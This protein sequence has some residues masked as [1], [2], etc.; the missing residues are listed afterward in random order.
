MKVFGLEIRSQSQ[1]T[2]LRE[3]MS[4]YKRTLEDI[5]WIN[6]SMDQYSREEL[7][8]GGFHFMLKRCRIMYVN[9]PLCKHWV[10]LTTSFV[11]GRGLTVP[12]SA[13]KD[14]DINDI[15][16]NFW[17][18]PDNKKT[19]SSVGPQRM[20]SNKMQYEGNLFFM[21]FDDDEGNVRVR[22]LNTVE[23]VDIITD[24]EDR[25]KYLFYKV[26]LTNRSYDYGADAYDN[27]KTQFWYIPD[28]DNEDPKSYGVPQ[29]KLKDDCRIFHVRINCDINDKF[30]IPDLYAGLDWVKA[31]KDMAGDVAT[32][33]KALSQFA[34]KKKVKGGAAQVNNILGQMKARTNLSN[35]STM[36]GKTQIENEGIDLESIDIKTGGVD[37]GEKGLKA[38]QMMVCSASGIFYHYYGDPSTGNLATATSMELPMVKKFQD[39]QMLWTY[40]YNVIFM[41]LFRKKI[42]VGLL[43][44]SVEFD[45]KTGYMYINTPK[46]L[47]VDLDF[48]PIIEQD[49]LKLGQ[50]L[51]IA[52]AQGLVSDELASRLF[53]LGMEVDDIDIEVE[54]AMTDLQS[55]RAR[56]SQ[57]V[58]GEPANKAPIDQSSIK[59]QNNYAA[60]EIQ[61]ALKVIK[62]L[63]KALSIR[64]GAIEVPE[65]QA[66]RLARKSNY[67]NQ[68]M[69]GYRKALSGH[70]RSFQ[71]DVKESAK[72]AGS[73]DKF[74]GNVKDLSKHITKLG[75]GMKLAAKTYFPE[76][77]KIGEKYIQSHL[78]SKGHKVQE[79]LYEKQGSAAKV[80][81]KSLDANTNY[82][83]TSLLPDINDKVSGAIKDQYAS[84]D[85][86]NTA[87][88]DAV[89][90]FESRMEMYVG[91][92]WAVE[93]SAVK[94][95]GTGTGLQVNFVGPEDGD[96]CEDCADAVAGNPYDIDEAPQPGDQQ[97]LTRCRHA[98][99]IV[100]DNSDT[101]IDSSEE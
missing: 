28:I 46:D 12:T 32:L 48:P 14:E 64:E 79:T 9:N 24:N 50:A 13:A 16:E 70:F 58:T 65:K 45:A 95:A 71:K 83:D 3:E 19:I 35:I 5:G 2:A 81:Q 27:Q 67:L 11:F 36:A 30:G 73:G 10:H 62:R 54:A 38:M 60:P 101:N 47:T 17:D 57:M 39:Y 77:V 88:S 59:Q 42:E 23:V 78:I 74:V 7:I 85:D 80:L 40:I 52:K 91:Y 72:V 96:N 56:N 8:A 15:L 53:L 94:E 84:S 92:L 75:N 6:L 69:N 20:I 44:G 90:S 61:E 68:R 34:W 76:A 26:S 97:C 93:E 31:H 21:L 66:N 63:E 41:Y 86:F 99:Q 51:E 98:L 100:D 4:L 37:I 22:L 55:D 29:G 18:D 82:I 33:V 43:E 49:I 25:N 1:E 89:N 87:V